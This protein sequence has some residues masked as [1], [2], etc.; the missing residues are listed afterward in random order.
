MKAY[1]Y[2]DRRPLIHAK[3][4]THELLQTEIF[5]DLKGL[6]CLVEH[7]DPVQGEYPD[8]VSRA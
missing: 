4:R 1:F 5:R 3:A 2:V 6:V 7:F 8:L